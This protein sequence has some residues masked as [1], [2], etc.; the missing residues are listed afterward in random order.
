MPVIHPDSEL[1]SFRFAGAVEDVAQVRNGI[2]LVWEGAVGKIFNSGG[3][4]WTAS[5]PSTVITFFGRRS[6]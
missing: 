6:D 4:Y 3:L 5:I 1:F 2:V